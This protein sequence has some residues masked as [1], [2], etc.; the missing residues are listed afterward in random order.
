MGLLI[1][2]VPAAVLGH[3]KQPQGFVSKAPKVTFVNPSGARQRDNREFPSE[4]AVL[5]GR[6]TGSRCHAVGRERE[7]ETAGER[8]RRRKSLQELALER[9][10]ADARRHRP[11]V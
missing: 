4:T 8:L 11:F 5:D 7:F 2:E 10:K 1:E 9:R 3:R 6:R